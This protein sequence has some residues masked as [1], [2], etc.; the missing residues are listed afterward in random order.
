MKSFS[1]RRALL[2]C[3]TCARCLGICF[4]VA[5]AAMLEAEVGE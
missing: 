5:V 2:S 4:G 3:P 1:E